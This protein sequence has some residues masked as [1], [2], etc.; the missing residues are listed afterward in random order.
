VNGTAGVVADTGGRRLA[1]MGFTV[2]GGRIV[3]TSAIGPIAGGHAVHHRL[4]AEAQLTSGGECKDRV[5]VLARV[6]L[7]DQSLE[8]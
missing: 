5:P 8:A 3:Q 4:A 1:V 6:M 2:R 7:D